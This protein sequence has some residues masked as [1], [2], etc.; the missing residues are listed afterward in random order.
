MKR[1][2]SVLLAICLLAGMGGI[3]AAAS[4]YALAAGDFHAIALRPDH[5]VWTWGYNYAGQMGDGTRRD[6]PAPII[7]P[8]LSDVVDVAAGYGHTIALKADGTV[9]TWGDNRNG[10]LGLGDRRDRGI[11]TRVMSL[12]DVIAV[13]ASDGKSFA[14]KED[15]SVWEWG[16]AFEGSSFGNNMPADA[17]TPKRVDISG[18]VVIAAKNVNAFALKSDGTVWSWGDNWCGQLGDGTMGMWQGG[19]TCRL[20]PGQVEG[21]TDVTAIATGGYHSFAW[22][23]DGTI[24]AWGSNTAGC[25]GDGTQTSSSVP[26]EIPQLTDIAAISAHNSYTML[27]KTDGTVWT[28]GLSNFESRLD[29]GSEPHYIP[30]QVPGLTDVV[31]VAA[32]LFFAA[33]LQEDG[34]IWCWGDNEFGQL[35]DGTTFD[36]AYPVQ[37]LGAVEVTIPEDYEETFYSDPYVVIGS[38]E[39]AV[40]SATPEITW[41]ESAMRL[42]VAQ[43]L[44]AGTYKATL[45]ASDAEGHSATKTVTIRVVKTIFSTGYESNFWNWF[46]FIVLFG[47]VWMWF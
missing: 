13:T 32:G 33:A 3:G 12:S 26:V 38:D 31:A 46:K 43:G 5:T 40:A 30:T 7:I 18:V 34:T 47:W 45:A 20:I 24:W 41:N 23:S 4:G 19:T 17:T 35:G 22:K 39:I 1:T 21:L 15:G 16:M 14:L 29:D 37:I 44:P 25:F 2:F 9:W 10:Q 8:G 27:L 42:E 6:R 36:S 28:C 11:P